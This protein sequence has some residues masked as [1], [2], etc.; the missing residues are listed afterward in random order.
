MSKNVILLILICVG[1]F[2]FVLPRGGKGPAGNI[3]WNTLAD[4]A[5]TPESV[6][7]ANKPAV[8]VFTASWCPPC[9]EMKQKTWPDPRVE[10]GIKPYNAVWV[11]IDDH[12]ELSQKFGIQSIPTIVKLD[13]ASKELGRLNGF[14]SPEAMAEWL[15][16]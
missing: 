4:A 2:V 1:L 15:A 6:A 7:N 9:K 11:D 14:V 3:A 16:R 13:A 5:L 8:V 10:A 12:P